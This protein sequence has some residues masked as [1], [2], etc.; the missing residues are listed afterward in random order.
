MDVEVVFLLFQTL[1]VTCCKL[2][3]KNAAEENPG[4]AIALNYTRCANKE[5]GFYHSSV[6]DIS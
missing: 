4:L 5:D 2:T 3:N 1:P 6:G